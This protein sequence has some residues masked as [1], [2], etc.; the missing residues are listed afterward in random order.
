MYSD[1]RTLAR[2]SSVLC[3]NAEEPKVCNAFKLRML[4]MKC[5]LRQHTLRHCEKTNVPSEFYTL[6]CT[7]RYREQTNVPS[8]AENIPSDQGSTTRPGPGINNK[9]FGCPGGVAQSWSGYPRYL[10]G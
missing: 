1:L 9:K 8:A 6:R 5:A 7:L 4:L 10:Q 2:Q 3:L